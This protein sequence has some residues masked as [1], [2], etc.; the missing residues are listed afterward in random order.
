MR[1][2]GKASG[3]IASVYQAALREAFTIAKHR[4]VGAGATGAKP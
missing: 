2:L 4:D 1:Q 3:E